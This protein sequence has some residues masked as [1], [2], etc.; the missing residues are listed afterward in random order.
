MR[1]PRQVA[2]AVFVIM[3]GALGYEFGA[4]RS[5]PPPGLTKIDDRP[6]YP[7]VER[8]VASGWIEGRQPTVDV[9][10]RLAEQIDQ[11]LVQEGEWVDQGAVLI[12]LDASR[13]R[14]EEDL[15]QAELA[16]ARARLVRLEN[17]FRDSEIATVRAELNA[18]NAELE[19]ARRTFQRL[20]ALYQTRAA[21]QQEYE[22]ELARV[23]SLEGTCEAARNRLV[24]MEEPAH[25]EDINVAKSAVEACKSR[26]ELA[27]LNLERTRIRAPI[28]GRVLRINA[29][30]GEIALP[31]EV[32]PLVV[33]SDI[34]ELHAVVEVDEFDSLHVKIGQRARLTVDSVKGTLAEGKVVRIEP[35]M[36]QK[37]MN[38]N[39]PGSRVDSLSRRVWVALESSADFPIGLPVDV[40]IATPSATFKLAD[41]EHVKSVTTH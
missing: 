22:E 28:D 13:F 3:V 36:S 14:V 40:E 31:E 1:V 41:Q 34:R 15:A 27:K 2:S 29:E 11:I 39:R 32:K 8:I 12:L 20:A 10:S 5:T 37:Q 16:G 30:K 26:L 9:R 21:S 18:R 24:T 25:R 35:Q 6:D 7:A 4:Y 19:G 38:M 23:R 33:L 17:G